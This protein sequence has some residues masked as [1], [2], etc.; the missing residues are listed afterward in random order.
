MGMMAEDKLYHSCVVLGFDD[1]EVGMV[2]FLELDQEG[3][4]EMWIL[5]SFLVLSA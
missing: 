2:F 3:D 5:F 1:A 4:Q